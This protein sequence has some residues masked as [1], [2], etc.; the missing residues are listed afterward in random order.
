MGVTNE[1]L[2][3][4]RESSRHSMQ[5][6]AGAVGIKV[7]FYMQIEQGREPGTETARKI[8]TFFGV[9]TLDI[10]PSLVGKVSDPPRDVDENS[11]SELDKYR[12][13]HTVLKFCQN[14]GLKPPH[15]WSKKGV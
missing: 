1:R 10:F 7:K 4:L 3:Q 14:L 15:W 6:V 5:D 12:Y 13:E 8:A 11:L 9:P 2:V